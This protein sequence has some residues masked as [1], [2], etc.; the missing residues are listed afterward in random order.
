MNQRRSLSHKHMP[1]LTFWKE[2]TKIILALEYILCRVYTNSFGWSCD[3]LASPIKNM[4]IVIGFLPSVCY[5][6]EKNIRKLLSN[7]SKTGGNGFIL[8][9]FKYVRVIQY[10]LKYLSISYHSYQLTHL[11]LCDFWGGCVTNQVPSITHTV[12]IYVLIRK[13]II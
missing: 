8:K 5:I 11:V 13:I 1:T 10:V 6:K 2:K 9:I 3:L 12:F 7:F 4:G